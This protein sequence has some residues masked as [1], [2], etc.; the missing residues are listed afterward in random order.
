MKGSVESVKY[1]STKCS[2]F[3]FTNFSSGSSFPPE[4]SEV[5]HTLESDR[6]N[7]IVGSHIKGRFLDIGAGGGRWTLNFANKAHSIIAL[8]PSEIYNILRERTA[9][10]NN[11][12]CKKMFFEEFETDILFDIV[13][14][15]GVL[16]YIT[17]HKE[18]EAFLM[19]ALKFIKSGGYLILRE[20]MNRKTRWNYDWKI[21]Q[22]K[23]DKELECSHYY[24]IIRA[25]RFYENVCNEMGFTKVASFISHA[26]FFYHLRF[27]H[28]ET[29][30]R[31]QD[32]IGNL[33]HLKNYRYI[34]VYNKLTG[35]LEEIL[36]YLINM[37]CIKV[38]ICKKL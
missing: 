32:I 20:P 21:C 19:K 37:R 3:E 5:I 10:L 27:Y 31:V 1:W 30:K 22:F 4:M 38:M 18:A 17:S 16:M 6:I 15:S 35:K 25:Q 11:V 24:E 8:E 14:I 33:I 28:Q 2:A 7:K 29:S 13:I 12:K 23:D 34:Q 9:H 36:R 26:S